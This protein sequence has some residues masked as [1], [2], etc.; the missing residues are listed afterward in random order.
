M[1]DAIATASVG[2]SDPILSYFSAFQFIFDGIRTLK[3]GY[4]KTIPLSL[5]YPP[6]LESIR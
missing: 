4:G 5:Y 2:F 3:E 1:L 6:F